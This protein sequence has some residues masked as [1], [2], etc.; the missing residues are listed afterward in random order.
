MKYTCTCTFFII[1]P[2]LFYLVMRTL[3]IQAV[4]HLYKINQFCINK[5]KLF[6]WGG[7]G[8]QSKSLDTSGDIVVIR[9]QKGNSFLP[10][11]YFKSAL[12]YNVTFSGF[13]IPALILKCLLHIAFNTNSNLF[14]GL[15]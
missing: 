2:L 6:V 5:V 9:N 14:P 1:A 11:H 10:P 13:I 4:S 3:R 7:W 15:R 8:L 12:V